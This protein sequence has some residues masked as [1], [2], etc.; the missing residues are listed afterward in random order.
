MPELLLV[1]R[2]ALNTRIACISVF[3]RMPES[4]ALP[5]SR[6]SLLG[7]LESPE[8]LV[9]RESLCSFLFIPVLL[10]VLLWLI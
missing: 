9:S 4:P 6:V 3:A 7:T 10:L 1:T 5:V 2:K 8:L